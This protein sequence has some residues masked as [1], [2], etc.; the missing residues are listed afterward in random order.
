MVSYFLN[1]AAKT[2]LYGPKNLENIEIGHVF[3]SRA[4]FRRISNLHTSC[5]SA[6]NIDLEKISQWAYHWKIQFNPDPNKQ[7]NEITFCC[8]L[9]SS[10]L[11][12]PLVKFNN[13]N[14]TRRS[15]Q[16]H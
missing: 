15:H 1:N 8:K 6:F 3:Q 7:A 9:V 5:L 12:H 2:C 14:I 13:N 4:F 16:K 11:S 10:N